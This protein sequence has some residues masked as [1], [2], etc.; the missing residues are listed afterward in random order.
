MLITISLSLIIQTLIVN[1]IAKIPVFTSIS[2]AICRSLASL[3][4][5]NV[6]D[7]NDINIFWFPFIKEC[8]DIGFFNFQKLGSYL[9]CSNILTDIKLINLIYGCIGCIGVSLLIRLGDKIYNQNIVKNI[10]VNNNYLKLQILKN[11]NLI[12]ISQILIFLDPIGISYTSALS[13]DLFLFSAIVSIIYLFYYRS[14]SITIFSLI[15]SITCFSDRPYAAL[16]IV[17]ALLLSL[18]IPTLKIDS[19][20]RK[21]QFNIPRKFNLIISY[22]FLFIFIIFIPA[23]IFIIYKLLILSYIENF[24]LLEITN[25]LNLWNRDMVGGILSYSSNLPF[26]IKYLFFWIL[27]LPIIQPGYGSI[28]FGISTINYLF[29]ITYI[30]QKGIEFNSYRIKFLLSLIII[31]S[32]L[33]SYISFN[34]GVTSRYKFTSCVAPL[35]LIFIYS[36]INYIKNKFRNYNE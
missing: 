30:F 19:F 26:F 22:K 14:L 31:F 13:K 5:T 9:Y 29:F 36:N 11:Y 20:L 17:G 1:K 2:I 33:F 23:L 18:Y 25:Y 21:I 4:Y 28:I 8:K 35:Y 32:V 6:F 24:N 16:F 7:N 3:L 27:P 15:V 10:L 34:S 12:R